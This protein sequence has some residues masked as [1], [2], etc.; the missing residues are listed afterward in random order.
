[1]NKELLSEE[2]MSKIIV[3]YLQGSEGATEEELQE[4]DNWAHE[5]V[6]KYA[7][8]ELILAGEIL[9]KKGKD[10]YCFR[11]VIGEEKEKL[12]QAYIAISCCTDDKGNFIKRED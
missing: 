1:M 11:P 12:A 6:V 3:N 10:G 5:I 8:L 7:L 4:L 2:K 9:I